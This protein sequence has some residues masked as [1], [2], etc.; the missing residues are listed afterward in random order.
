MSINIY[1]G[2]DH[3]ITEPVFGGGRLHNDYGRGFYCTED[4]ELA[5][6][7]A[8]DVGRDGF[9]N[10]YTINDESLDI[11]RLND[12]DFTA[13]HWLELLLSNRTFDITTPLAREAVRYLHANFHVDCSEKDIIIGYRADDSYFSYAQDFIN[14]VISISQL[15]KALRLGDLGLQ[16]V[17]KSE[18]AFEHLKYIKSDLVL[19]R[20]WYPV[21]KLRDS[22]VRREYYS[23]DRMAYVRNDIYIKAAR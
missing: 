15:T 16:Y 5:M 14:N 21:K 6:E 13:L 22:K 9:V 11:L 20:E 8:V 19:A 2:S 1:H 18:R 23:F 10:C 17:L 3:I 7:W 4:R 12:G